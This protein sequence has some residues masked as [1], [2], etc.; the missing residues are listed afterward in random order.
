MKAA[1]GMAMSKEFRLFVCLL[2]VGL[3]F[4]ATKPLHAVLLA[5]AAFF[6]LRP[7]LIWWQ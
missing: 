4:L 5:L 7:R 2:A 6:I 3:I 1:E